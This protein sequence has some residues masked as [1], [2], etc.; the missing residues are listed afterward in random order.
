MILMMSVISMSC[1]NAQNNKVWD[2]EVKREFKL[3]SG[4]NP[5][6]YQM[7]ANEFEKEGANISVSVFGLRELS[8]NEVSTYLELM[9]NNNEW[10][11]LFIADFS[12][13]SLNEN[14]FSLP[15]TFGIFIKNEAV[16]D[17]VL[18]GAQAP[19]NDEVKDRYNVKNLGTIYEPLVLNAGMTFEGSVLL[20]ID[21]LRLGDT[22]GV[23]EIYVGDGIGNLWGFSEIDK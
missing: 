2:Y 17:Y 8:D 10:I 15:P 9:N 6:L 11:R 14:H 1:S 5:A 3:V 22:E 23:T 20:F 7:E 19:V 12:M 4:E 16:D 18:I 13:T 21:I